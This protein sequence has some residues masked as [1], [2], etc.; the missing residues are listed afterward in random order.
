MEGWRSPE[1]PY[2]TRYI[3]LIYYWWHCNARMPQDALQTTSIVPWV[4]YGLPLLDSSIKLIAASVFTTR[5]WVID[6]NADF[7]TSQ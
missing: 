4:L 1:K 7:A 2:V 6:C 5:G 3:L